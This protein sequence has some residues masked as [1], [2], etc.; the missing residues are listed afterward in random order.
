M[1][2]ELHSK[3]QKK[4]KILL[5]SSSTGNTVFHLKFLFGVWFYQ[6]WKQKEGARGQICRVRLAL[7]QV[8]DIG[9]TLLILENGGHHLSGR[10]ESL[11]LPPSRFVGWSANFRLFLGLWCLLVD[12]W[13]GG[14]NVAP[15]VQTA[16]PKELPQLYFAPEFPGRIL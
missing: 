3:I 7:P 15:S 9:H 6:D 1:H 10:P 13:S 4:F 2:C 12:P 8:V 16:F 14:R 11:H 5:I